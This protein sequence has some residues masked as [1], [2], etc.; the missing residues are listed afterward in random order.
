L[1]CGWFTAKEAL[2]LVTFGPE[3]LKLRDALGA[4]D[5]PVYRVYKARPFELIRE[6]ERW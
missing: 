5:R 6:A 3:L 1:E 4:N 2:E